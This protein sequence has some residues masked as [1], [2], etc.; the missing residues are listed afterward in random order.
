MK[1]LKTTNTTP[2]LNPTP[3]RIQ[4]LGCA[5]P[6]RAWLLDTAALLACSRVFVALALVM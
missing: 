3:V 5:Y 2:G 4:A 6:L 1:S